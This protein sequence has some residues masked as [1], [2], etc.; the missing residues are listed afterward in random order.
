MELASK[1]G[2]AVSKALNSNKVLNV[3]LM[4]AFGL[5]CMRSVQQ[6]KNMEVLEA[7]KDSLLKSNKAMKKDMWDWKQQLFAEAE[8]PN[9]LIPLSKIKAIYGDVQ[10]TTSTS[11]NII[12][13]HSSAC[14]R[15]HTLYKYYGGKL[16]LTLLIIKNIQVEMLITEMENHLQEYLLSESHCCSLFMTKQVVFW[17]NNKRPLRSVKYHAS[18]SRMGSLGKWCNS[19]FSLGT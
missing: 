14:A 19:E 12:H 5:L 9:P 1:V 8:L 15:A 11:G 2:D 4:S 7:E 10:T 6:Q 13:K 3:V 17:Q 16:L 18:V